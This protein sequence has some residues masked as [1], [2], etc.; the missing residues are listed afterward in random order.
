MGQHAGSDCD[1]AAL[2]WSGR[3][4]YG[5]ENEIIRILMNCQVLDERDI[6]RRHMRASADVVRLRGGGA[7]RTLWIRIITFG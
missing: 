2:L 3:V 6:G 7:S 5:A 1:D 4:E